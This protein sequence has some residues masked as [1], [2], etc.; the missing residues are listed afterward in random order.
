MRITHLPSGIVVTATEERSQ[1]QN[2]QVARQRLTEKLQTINDQYQHNSMN[3]QRDSYN[4][5][6]IAFVWTSWRDEVKMPNGKKT[7]MKKALSGKL[8]PLLS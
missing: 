2:R 7:S 8:S 6:E 1:H 4:N 3:E 5:G